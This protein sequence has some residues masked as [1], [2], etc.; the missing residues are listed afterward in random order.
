MAR[1]RTFATTWAEHRARC[2]LHPAQM[3]CT[4]CAR[5]WA[6]LDAAREA[7]HYLYCEPETHGIHETDCSE[8]CAWCIAEAALARILDPPDV[9]AA[10]FDDTPKPRL[11]PMP[12]EWDA[13]QQVLA[14]ADYLL[15]F[16]RL[17]E[18]ATP[19]ERQGFEWLHTACQAAQDARSEPSVGRGDPGLLWCADDGCVLR[20]A[21]R[22]S[23]AGRRR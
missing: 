16:K 4:R 21:G 12:A 3:S 20:D 22:R 8:M 23:H 10:I 11:P 15:G 18:S 14:S 2:G 19:D 6:L 17:W 5:E 7:Y 1:E 9:A 13:L